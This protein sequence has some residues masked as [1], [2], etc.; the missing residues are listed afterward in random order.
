MMR[1]MNAYM[2]NNKEMGAIVI[3]HNRI[4]SALRVTGVIGTVLCSVASYAQAPVT[5]AAMPL[6]PT[7]EDTAKVIQQETPEN[8]NQVEVNVGKIDFADPAKSDKGHGFIVK[9]GKRTNS[10]FKLFR[11]EALG[12]HVLGVDTHFQSG[13]MEPVYVT[14]YVVFQNASG[15][16]IGTASGSGEVQ[17]NTDNGWEDGPVIALPKSRFE[18]IAYY[19]VVLYE[20]DKPV[21]TVLTEEEAGKA[22]EAEDSTEDST[23]DTKEDV[24]EN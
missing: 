15:S 18:E 9:I 10:Q 6:T 24:K 8:K 16:V 3:R 20:S 21:G 22:K 13:G 23:Q 4:R 7:T 5:D 14:Y 1:K 11:D 2:N 17:P 19:Q 12:K